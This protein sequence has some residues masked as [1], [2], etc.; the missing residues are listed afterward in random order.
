MSYRLDNG[1]YITLS[2]IDSFDSKLTITPSQK[3]EIRIKLL[4]KILIDKT[5]SADTY[6]SMR[7]Q[8]DEAVYVDDVKIIIEIANS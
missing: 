4:E 6:K 8:I 3:M 2:E 7:V 5:I 1:N